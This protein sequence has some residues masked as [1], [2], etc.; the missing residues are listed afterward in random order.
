LKPGGKKEDL[1]EAFLELVNVNFYH[2]DKAEKSNL[3]D[4]GGGPK[5]SWVETIILSAFGFVTKGKNLASGPRQS[6]ENIEE[7]KDRHA[8]RKK[9]SFDFQ[10]KAGGVNTEMLHH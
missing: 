4:G 7:K 10:K 8:D 2:W 3:C 9:Q 5:V 6:P 1:K